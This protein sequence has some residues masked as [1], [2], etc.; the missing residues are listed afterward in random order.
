[1]P[2][3]NGEMNGEGPFRRMKQSC[4]NNGKCNRSSCRTYSTNSLFIGFENSVSSLQYRSHFL[5]NVG[6]KKNLNWHEVTPFQ[7]QEPQSKA[8]NPIPILEPL[9]NFL[10]LIHWEINSIFIN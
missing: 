3:S 6:K 7:A 8:T 1:M 5:K 9:K 10:N 2:I 4:K